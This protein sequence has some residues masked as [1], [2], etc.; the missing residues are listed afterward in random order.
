MKR[1]AFALQ[2][3]LD[4]RQR[5][6]DEKQLVVAARKRAL[7]EAERERARLNDE[8]RRHAAALRERH[9]QL[10]T[11]ELQSIYAHLQFL[12]RCIVAQIRVVAERRV[13]LDRAR[14]DLLEASKEKKVVEK[15]KARRREAFVVEERRVEQRELDDG[16]ARRYGRTQLGGSS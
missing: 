16:N 9:K 5:I 11:R 2:P 8:F 1:F 4:H 12:D 14:A 6:E 15:L 13:A 7:D 3:V 10:E